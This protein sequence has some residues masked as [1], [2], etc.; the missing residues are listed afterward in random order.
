MKKAKKQRPEDRRKLETVLTDF[1]GV[2]MMQ[3]KKQPCRMLAAD[4]QKST[5]HNKE[6][7]HSSMLVG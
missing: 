7:T 1:R 2:A 4:Y 3:A 5:Q 6:V